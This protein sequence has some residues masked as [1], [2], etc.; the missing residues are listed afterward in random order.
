MNDDDL[1]IQQ[2]KLQKE[3]QEVLKE[4]KVIEYLEKV[5]VVRQIGS[6][7]LGLMVWRD[8]DIQVSSPALSISHAFEIMNPI[9]S[10]PFVKHVRYFHQ[11][12]LFKLDGLDERLFFMVFYE[13]QTDEEWKL[14]ISF[15]LADGLRPEPIQDFIEQQLTTETR[16]IILRIKN[17]WYKLPNY[18]TKVFSTDIYDAVLKHGVRD[19]DGFDTYLVERGKPSLQESL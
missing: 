12:G 18:R 7:T 15:W 10:H 1:V 2:N 13:S 19:V 16:L 6:T 9:L 17:V 3:S 8:I 14:D 5:G 4:L 11:S